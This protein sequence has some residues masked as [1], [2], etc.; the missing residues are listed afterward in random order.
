MKRIEIVTYKEKEI[1]RFDYRGL[2]E[3]G[4]FL[5]A[6]SQGAKFL[7]DLGRPTLQLTNIEGLFFTPPIMK[8]IDEAGKRIEHLVIKDAIVGVTGVKRILFQA[9]NAVVGGKAKAFDTEEEALEWLVK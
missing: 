5:E 7:L 9:Y 3:D 4:E 2:T 6:L 8:K 1:V